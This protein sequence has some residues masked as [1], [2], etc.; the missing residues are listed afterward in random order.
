MEIT[1]RDCRDG[2]QA[3]INILKL[4]VN[5]IKLDSNKPVN[6]NNIS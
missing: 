2:I 5:Q 4:L 6:L 1:H 3:F